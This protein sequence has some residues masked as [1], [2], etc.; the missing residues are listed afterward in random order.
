MTDRWMRNCWQA[1]AY[2]EEIS[3]GVLPRK[4]LNEAIVFFRTSDGVVHALA[5]KCAHRGLPLSCGRRRGD[6]LECGYHGMTYDAE[7]TCVRAPGQDR[8]P[9][10]AVVKAYP[11]AEK[12]GFVWVWMGQPEKSASAEIPNFFWFKSDE[13]TCAAGYH[14]IGADYRLLNDNLLDLSHESFVHQE[15]IGNAAVADSPVTAEIVAGTVRVS[16]YM[17]ACD[18]PPFYVRVTGFTEKIDRWHTTIFTPPGFLVI[19]N[20]SMPTGSDRGAAKERRVL[21]LVT[22][23]TE[24]SSHYFW[25]IA[26]QY[27]KDDADLTEFL[28]T[29]TATTFDQDKDI[30]EAQ[31]RS[32][33]VDPENAFAVKM[34]IDI[35]PIL[36]RKLLDQ[37]LEEDIHSRTLVPA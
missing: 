26:R 35:G 3:D 20:G 15:T 37:K 34:K 23:E 6:L 33:G 14:L 5:D 32:L 31:Q 28:R 8:V 30:L 13:W 27:D 36:G 18:P 21:H 1:A 17:S 12:H 10:A 22:P 16:R 7:G 29:G 9:S 4:I 2:A 11:V 25:G 19:E 24:S